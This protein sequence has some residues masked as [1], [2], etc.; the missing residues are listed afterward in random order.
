[1][2]NNILRK[3]KGFLDNFDRK[4]G[5]DKKVPHY[6]PGCGHGR[7]HKLIAEAMEKLEI[8]DNTIFVSPVGCSVFG[9]YYFSCGNVQAAHGRAPAVGTAI[10][11]AN[12]DNIVISYQ[13]DG[14][15]GAIG[16]S[17][18]LHAANRGE[19]MTVIFVNNG[20]YGMTGGQ[21]A[22][23]TLE[24]QVSA[25]TPN[26][27]DVMD[28]GYPLKISEMI[29][30]MEAPVY[31]ERVAVN[32]AR[33][34]M[35]AKRAITKA[36]KSQKEHKGFSL[37]EILSSCPIGWK[38]T[39]VEAN[40]RITEEMVPQFPLKVFKDELK[41]KGERILD[42]PD[43][44]DEQIF[45]ALDMLDEAK[46]F[47][48][49]KDFVSSFKTQKL[50]IAGFGGQGVLMAGTTIAQLAMEYGLDV[51]WLPSYGPEMRGG[52]ANCHVVL[53]NT[54]VGS[55]L[56]EKPNVLIAMNQ[57]SL[58]EFAPTVVPN[59][60]IVVNSSVVVK[61]IERTD[62]KTFYVPMTEIAESMGLRAAANMVAVTSYLAATK[63]MSTENLQKL[64]SARFKKKALISKNIEIIEKAEAYIKEHY[65]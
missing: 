37:I 41:T 14:D 6:C 55:P 32:D 51:T 26:G 60:I 13:G 33:G 46:L 38:M 57:P 62:V 40:K 29:A 49:P 11:R 52:T 18:I 23:T 42:F 54:E 19:N 5:N 2:D 15:L 35:G 39:P 12:K 43:A 31:V 4:P 58:D 61:K 44:S 20:I 3:P 50:K 34:V 9:Y 7:I 25:T 22:P 53:S 8:I 59:G 24:G 27:R 30:T 17:E 36:L 10:T 21:M 48:T 16:L 45:K 28:Q 64:I 63:I 65:V 47:E 56:V 1:M